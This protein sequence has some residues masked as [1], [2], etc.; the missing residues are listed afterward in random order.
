MS[1][2]A[3]ISESCD[4]CDTCLLACPKI[5]YVKKEGSAVPEV[6]HDEL[7]GS[8]GHCVALCPHGA[9]THLDFPQASIRAI[10]QKIL[11]SA[12]QIVELLRAR[13]SMRVFADRPVERERIERIIDGAHLAPTAHNSQS[14]EFIVVQERQVLNQIVDLTARFFAHVMKLLRNPLIRNF[15]LLFARNLAESAIDSMPDFK[16]IVAAAGENKDLILHGAPCLILFHAARN[17]SF[18]N[19]N[20]N[21]ALQNATLVSQG[22]GLGSFYTGYVVVA[23]ERDGSIPRLLSLPNNHQVYAGLALGYPRLQFTNWIQR[24]PPRIQW[25]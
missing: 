7:C 19:A 4:G 14:T 13:R 6:V 5:I 8:C 23:C 18:A 1:K 25:M 15:Y 22:L 2:I 11:P 24:R 16:R 20:A 10:D 3:I 21:L 12:A 17:V 9:I